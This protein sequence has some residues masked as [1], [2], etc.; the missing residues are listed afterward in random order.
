MTVPKKLSIAR[1]KERVCSKKDVKSDLNE[2]KWTL[3]NLLAS[4]ERFIVLTRNVLQ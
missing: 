1:T 3:I 2:K 4:I